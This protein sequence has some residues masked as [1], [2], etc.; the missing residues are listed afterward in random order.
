MQIQKQHATIKVKQ[1][2]LFWINVTREI[3]VIGA[4]PQSTAGVPF[5][6]ELNSQNMHHNELPDLVPKY[7]IDLHPDANA[8]DVIDSG[9]L[10]FGFVVGEKVKRILK[11]FNLPPHRFYPV[12]VTGTNEKYYWFHYI[13]NFWDYVDFSH[14]EIQV[15]DKF[16]Y[17]LQETKTFNSLSDVMKFKKDLSRQSVI[18]IGKIRLYNDF[19][20][21]DLF[22]IS[23]PQN[24]TVIRENLK[25]RF[26]SET[27]SGFEMKQYNKIKLTEK[28]KPP[29]SETTPYKIKWSQLKLILDKIQIATAHHSGAEE[30]RMLMKKLN[31]DTLL[32]ESGYYIKDSVSTDLALQRLIDTYD[33]SIKVSEYK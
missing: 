14:T 25:N 12:D 15:I 2:K 6:G 9:N 10:P 16:K 17:T 13:T 22:H 3:D 32:I 18:R 11:E 4:Y 27:I 21:W 26:T 30:L 28:S 1:M 29:A 33:P 20:H 7:G 24:F 19:P 5:Y 31:S 23:G 8:T